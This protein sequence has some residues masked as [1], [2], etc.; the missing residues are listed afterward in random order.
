M[1]KYT[2]KQ[3][4]KQN[5]NVAL[6]REN[7]HIAVSVLGLT[8]PGSGLWGPFGLLCLDICDSHI[9]TPVQLELIKNNYISAKTVAK[10]AI[11]ALP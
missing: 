6:M 4:N 11:T 2:E 9:L 10:K 8:S 7:S 1:V 3:T 5:R